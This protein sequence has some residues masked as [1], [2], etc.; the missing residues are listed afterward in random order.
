MKTPTAKTSSIGQLRC[1]MFGHN[2]V[3]KQK[4]TDSV[5]EYCCSNCKGEFSTNPQGKLERLTN[6]TREIN[7]CL[8]DLFTRRSK[9]RLPN[10]TH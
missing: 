7:E 6:K 2:L 10:V 9:Y 1:K 8:R 5:S 4:V 3:L